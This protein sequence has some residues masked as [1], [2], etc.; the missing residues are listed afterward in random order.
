MRTHRS[1]WKRLGFIKTAPQRKA[2]MQ[3]KKYI[4]AIPVLLFCVL[5]FSI[6]RA[7]PVYV[8]QYPPD[9]ENISIYISLDS[10][11]YSQP[12]LAFQGNFTF[13]PSVVIVDTVF[14][15]GVISNTGIFSHSVDSTNGQCLFAYAG[16]EGIKASGLIINVNMAIVDPGQISDTSFIINL[17]IQ[18]NEGSPDVDIFYN[19][20][21]DVRVNEYIIPGQ[22]SLEQNYPN[23]FNPS[24]T[25]GY[26]LERHAH[27]ELSIYEI[28]GRK[29]ITLVNKY[30]KAGEY[31]IDWNGY[32]QKG[33]RVASG[34][35]FYK[36]SVNEFTI[37]RKMILL[38]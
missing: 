20:Y 23:P 13:N 3:T 1:H 29:T 10:V 7:N 27:V 8:T 12:I 11:E 21:L 25:I 28:R 14:N 24:T 33:I 4:E 19:T 36:V 6:A 26:T 31:S 2:P 30:Q 22:F 32:D 38:K 35:Y 5:L 9:G 15:A 34:I 16:A 17:Y 37:S 18:L